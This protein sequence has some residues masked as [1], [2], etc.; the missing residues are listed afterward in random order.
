CYADSCVV[1]LNEL[2]NS[3]SLIAR[4]SHLNGESVGI[5][6]LDEK[7]F[8]LFGV[9]LIAFDLVVVAGH[10]GREN[11]VQNL[12]VAFENSLDNSLSVNC[13]CHSLTYL[14]IVQGS[15]EIVHTDVCYTALNQFNSLEV[16]ICLYT[17]CVNGSYRVDKV[18][19]A[20]F[21]SYCKRCGLG[22]NAD[23]DLGC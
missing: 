3:V 18:D 19:L 17:L 16:G 22:D 21:K 12:A 20:V 5:T 23:C 8:C 1:S 10:H 2:S 4:C 15:L 14:V 7:L 11:C 9:V 13:V 6:C